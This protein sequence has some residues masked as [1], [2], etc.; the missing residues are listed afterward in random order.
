MRRL[1]LDDA[2]LMLDIWTDPDFVRYVGDRGVE[3]REQ[4]RAAIAEGALLSYA[5]YGFGPYHVALHDGTAV[6][7]CGLYAR[8][9]LDHPDIGFALLAPHRGQGYAFEAAAAVLR[10]CANDL[11]LE[12]IY[13]IVAPANERSLALI[14]K[15][16]MRYHRALQ[17]D[18]D[19][20]LVSLYRLRLAQRED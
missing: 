17:L 18:G 5:E 14:T 20:S 12:W 1:T 3:T 4:A 11:Q 9:E 6:G 2:D 10:Y 15:L 8:S 19:D 16:G 13:A 7:V